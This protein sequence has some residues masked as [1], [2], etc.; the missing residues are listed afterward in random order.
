MVPSSGT[1][2]EIKALQKQDMERALTRH[3]SESRLIVTM[4]D[5][6]IK[7]CLCKAAD[8]GVDCTEKKVIT[9]LWDKWLHC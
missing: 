2:G 4:F 9:F 7:L 5:A 1:P 3:D 6:I 8:F